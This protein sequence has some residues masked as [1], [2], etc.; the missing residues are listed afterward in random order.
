MNL[1]NIH[2]GSNNAWLG[3]FGAVIILSF[4][5]PGIESG[6]WY[7]RHRH[8]ITCGPFSMHVPLF[9]TGTESI[10]TFSVCQQGFSII[11]LGT[12]L[13][14][15]RDGG[16]SLDVIPVITVVPSGQSSALENEFRKLHSD[17]RITPYSLNAD[18]SQCLF[19]EKSVER[20]KMIYLVCEGE[21]HTFFLYFSGTPHALSTI[22]ASMDH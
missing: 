12:T 3:V 4:F 7:L 21:G 9:W 10:D 2:L 13:I 16:N 1:K 15:S 8:V 11:N 17:A 5:S 18:F 20:R 14:G 22:T 19:S 6:W